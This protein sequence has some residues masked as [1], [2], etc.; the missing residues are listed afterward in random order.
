MPGFFEQA[1]QAMQMRNQMKR[2]QREIEEMTKE[3]SNGGVRVVVSG[4]MVVK[5]IE[6]ADK[7]LLS[8]AKE[9]KL[10]RTF[11]ENVNKALTLAKNEAQE[12][13]KAVTKELGLGGLG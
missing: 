4:D 10:L 9:E 2:L 11:T 1:K 6:I 5:A 3:Y 12:R 8:P 13:M 7:E